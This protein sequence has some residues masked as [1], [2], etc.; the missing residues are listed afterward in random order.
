M[1]SENKSR[2]RVYGWGEDLGRRH[3]VLSLH[4]LLL[5]GGSC[6]TRQ[7][8]VIHFSLHQRKLQMNDNVSG[9]SGTY[10]D[11][12]FTF[13]N[14]YVPEKFTLIKK[15]KGK[16]LIN[17]Q[18]FELWFK[19]TIQHYEIHDEVVRFGNPEMKIT[20]N[21]SYLKFIYNVQQPSEF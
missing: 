14:K 12:L 1:R 19:Y 5:P 15:M 11:F 21:K 7:Q 8:A 16:K 6:R 2:A 9:C 20:A 17:Q 13:C 10:A 18:F 3:G 4:I